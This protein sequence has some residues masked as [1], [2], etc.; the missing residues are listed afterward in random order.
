[1]TQQTIMNKLF[2]LSK[3]DL[4]I[5]IV[6]LFALGA[7]LYTINQVGDYQQAINRHWQ[8]Q[9]DESGCAVKSSMIQIANISFSMWEDYHDTD[10]DTD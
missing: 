10:Q 2:D 8:E 9:W 6:L 1:M 5:Y 7:C 3:K 4:M